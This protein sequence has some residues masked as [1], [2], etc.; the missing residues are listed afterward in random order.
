[1]CAGERK[2]HRTC[3]VVGASGLLRL[4]EYGA[5][6]DSHEA[7][8]RLNTQPTEG[9]ERFVG[10]KTTYNMVNVFLMRSSHRTEYVNGKKPC[11]IYLVRHEILCWFEYTKVLIAKWCV[12]L[13]GFRCTETLAV[14]CA[15]MRARDANNPLKSSSFR[16]VATQHFPLF[17]N[18]L[19]HPVLFGC[20]LLVTDEIG[21]LRAV[22]TPSH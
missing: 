10:T 9:Y 5:E 11:P 15:S 20:F 19:P 12:R 2:R 13:I 18:G 16:N 4:H 17:K 21:R 14:S 3:A 6:I 7:V 1:M 8:F 22:E